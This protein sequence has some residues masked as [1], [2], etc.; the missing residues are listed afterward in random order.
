MNT[1][2]PRMVFVRF[3]RFAVMVLLTLLGMCA[4]IL[5]P[6]FLSL[7]LPSLL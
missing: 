4:A 3:L 1:N 6:D 2:Q 5:A 7:S